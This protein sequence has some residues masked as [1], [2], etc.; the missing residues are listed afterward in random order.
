[1][2]AGAE[3]AA[4]GGRSKQ[5]P[6]IGKGAA[7][8]VAGAL[9]PA[10]PLG[11]VLHVG[12]SLTRRQ[13]SAVTEHSAAVLWATHLGRGGDERGSKLAQ[14]AAGDG[15][16]R[17]RKKNSCVPK[18]DENSIRRKPLKSIAFSVEKQSMFI[19]MKK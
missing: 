6:K 8:G 5:A 19:K 12:W 10:P 1:M 7:R 2:G 18:D 17:G 11:A 15:R 9:Q 14:P 4:P 3:E 13:L 16:G